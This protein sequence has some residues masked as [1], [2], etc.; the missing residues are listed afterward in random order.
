MKTAAIIVNYNMPERADDLARY[1][2]ENVKS[3]CD[4]ILVDNGSDIKKPAVH[5]NLRL[6]WNVQTTNGWLMGL[7]YAD[8]VEAAF[9]EKY[10]AYW[11]LITSAA[12]IDSDPLTPM[13][14][15]LE[16]DKDAVGVHPAL[17]PESTTSWGHMKTKA[18]FVCR[19]TWMID[20]IASL[21][22]ADWFNKNGRF[23]PRLIYGWGIDLET[24]YKA[25]K[26]DKKIFIHE[27]ARVEKITDI[28]YT[29]N[30]MNMSADDRQVKAS[31]NMHE[32]LGEKYGRGWWE[33]FTKEGQN[34]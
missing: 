13:I 4:V 3:P 29:M 20:N 12:F 17:T 28:G 30:R 2:Q 23:D 21:W 14:E 9:G 33:L 8:A 5:T 11:F 15:L 19:E 7:H 25:R 31:Q 16:N 6:R 10:G 34:D 24:C 32:I 26:Q 1:I 22:R 27:L 18:N